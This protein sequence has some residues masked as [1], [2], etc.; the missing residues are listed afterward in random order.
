MPGPYGVTATGFNPKS[1]QE[2]KA[3]IEAAWRV[4]FGQNVD[5]SADSVDG[6]IVG[7]LSDRLAD[8]WQ[9][10]ANVYGSAFA[11]S[12]VGVSLDRVLGL[13]G[14]V[15]APASK[16]QVNVIL[17][18]TPATVVP[19]GSR[20]SVSGS[21][22]LF[23]LTAPAVIGGGGSVAAVMTAVSFGP[24]RAPA[25]QLTVIETPVAGWSSLVN[26]ADQF[27]LGSLVEKDPAA[28]LRREL[29]LRA[30]GG[31]AL[32][33]IRAGVLTVEGVT[34]ARGF[35][36]TLETTVDGMP[37]GS[38]EIVVSGGLDAEIAQAIWDRKPS[39]NPLHGN[40][41]SAATDSLGEP[42]AIKFSRPV[43]LNIYVDLDVTVNSDAPENIAGVVAQA[44]VDFGDLNYAE[45]SSVV[46]MA[47][48]PSVFAQAGVV[49]CA[50]PRIGLVATPLTSTTI[51]STPRQKPDL[52]TSRVVV[53]VTRL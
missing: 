17:T 1:Q 5:V 32:D 29:E 36:N 16:T 6:Q 8:L 18:G 39:G 51:Q 44:L 24:M 41:T 15:R 49:D 20:A 28:R 43:A 22:T 12:A 30:I 35:Q 40:T 42:Q 7:I 13:A 9:G 19:S 2:I 34:S 37:P 11:D 31:S 52:D 27:F 50:V 48:T 21:G 45:G 38:I 23:E 3:D 4:A 33:A 53:N 46:A 26:A 10:L 25:G 14:V 47:L